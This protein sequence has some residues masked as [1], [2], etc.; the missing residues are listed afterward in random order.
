M[1]LSASV[2][3]APKHAGLVTSRNAR[4]M[5][6]EVRTAK[7]P[8]PTTLE[9][10]DVARHA[11]RCRG[12]L[13][14]IAHRWGY[15]GDALDVAID[16][17]ARIVETGSYRRYDPTQSSIDSWLAGAAMNYFRKQGEIRARRERIL[18]E[19]VAPSI[20][21]TYRPA[22]IDDPDADAARLARFR[23]RLTPS[24]AEVFDLA[25]RVGP[26][27]NLIARSLGWGV[28]RVRESLDRIRSAAGFVSF[29]GRSA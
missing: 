20:R 18:Q 21:T 4:A 19:N 16:L 10:E 5:P 27:T 11:L 29:G 28:K 8:R 22:P 2:K 17:A 23:L 9:P 6:F 15:D 25:L 3:P 13:A 1:T 7:N 24:E 26:R 14:T 12:H